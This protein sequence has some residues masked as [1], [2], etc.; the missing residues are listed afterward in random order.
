MK[1]F[2]EG[3]YKWSSLGLVII[4]L[5]SGCVLEDPSTEDPQTIQIP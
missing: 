2:K 5:L 4:M 1:L 3:Y